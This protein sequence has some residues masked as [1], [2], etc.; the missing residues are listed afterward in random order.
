MYAK[1]HPRA[2]AA[3]ELRVYAAHRRE[4]ERSRRN[5]EAMARVATAG[6]RAFDRWLD[7]VKSS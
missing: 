4:N 2:E 6:E 1:P 5:A 7:E 3:R